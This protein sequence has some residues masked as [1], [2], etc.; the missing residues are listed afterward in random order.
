MKRSHMRGSIHYYLTSEGG[1]Y[2]CL[3]ICVVCSAHMQKALNLIFSLL[4][5]TLPSPAS[6]MQYFFCNSRFIIAA[7]IL[8]QV[9]RCVNT[10]INLELST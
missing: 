3:Y 6:H 10:H 4:P 1:K 8:L 2:V 5:L 7:R 9:L